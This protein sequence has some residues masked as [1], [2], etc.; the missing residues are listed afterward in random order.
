MLADDLLLAAYTGCSEATGD[1][2]DIDE[3]GWRD[4]GITT[5]VAPVELDG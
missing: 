4:T 1:A 5:D 2:I 3:S